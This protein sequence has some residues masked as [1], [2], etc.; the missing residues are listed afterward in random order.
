MADIIEE[1]QA[2]IRRS[3]G[4]EM[5]LM[6]DV[7]DE[8]AELRKT[9]TA[10]LVDAASKVK[11]VDVLDDGTAMVREDTGFA[12]S[13][14]AGALKALEATEKAK[15]Q[16]IGLKMRQNEAEIASAA[17]HQDRILAVLEMTKPGNL[18]DHEFEPAALEHKMEEMFDAQIQGFEMNTNPNDLSNG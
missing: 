12:M 4:V 11:I 5:A 8:T 1:T 17:V 14:V 18:K 16:S 3:L 7:F 13:V 10:R 2:K 6:E 9:I 15:V